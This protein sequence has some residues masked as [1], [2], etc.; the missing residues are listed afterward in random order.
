MNSSKSNLE[1]MIIDDDPTCHLVGRL[2][3]RKYNK[4]LPVCTFTSPVAALEHIRSLAP[5]EV[6]AKTIVVFLDINM[7]E[8]TGWEV[9]EEL[10]K[11]DPRIKKML[12]IYIVSSS[13]DKADR[14]LAATK[15]NVREF[16]GKPVSLDVF[17]RVFA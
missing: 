17:R 9:M 5:D 6:T 16:I 8:L 11:L 1:L 12:E 10:D 14:E 4:D 13:I 2:T 7:P 15:S 3:A